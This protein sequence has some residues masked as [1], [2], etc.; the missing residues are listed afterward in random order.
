VTT[1]R[2]PRDPQYRVTLL[3][4]PEEL[5]LLMAAAKLDRREV[6]EWCLRVVLETAKRRAGDRQEGK[7]P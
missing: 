5:N 2:R 4:T 7:N 6:G 3:V 1:K